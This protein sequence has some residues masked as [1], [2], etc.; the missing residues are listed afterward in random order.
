MNYDRHV[1]KNWQE[2]RVMPFQVG[3]LYAWKGGKRKDGRTTF[4]LPKHRLANKSG[5]VLRYRLVYEENFGPIPPGYEIHHIDGNPSND[6]PSNLEAMPKGKHTSHH[7]GVLKRVFDD[8][9][10]GY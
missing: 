2:V 3:N 5:Y 1:G 10:K 4:Y 9:R 8:I 6:D 7:K